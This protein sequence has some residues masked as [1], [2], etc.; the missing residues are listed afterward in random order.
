MINITKSFA[1]SFPF[2]LLLLITYVAIVSSKSE[3][4]PPQ[5][6]QQSK[7]AVSEV[8]Q[9]N[10][11]KSPTTSQVG[12]SEEIED[13]LEKDDEDEDNDSGGGNS[14]EED[15]E[16][17]AE[18][19]GEDEGSVAEE[20]EYAGELRAAA[21]K[22]NSDESIANLASPTESRKQV[23]ELR[24]HRR[25][26]KSSTDEEKAS[27][28]KRESSVKKELSSQKEIFIAE[29]ET[30]LQLDRPVR[31]EALLDD[32]AQ[33]PN[34]LSNELQETENEDR[35]KKMYKE[36][37]P[38]V[39]MYSVP[40]AK[41]ALKKLNKR[42]DSLLTDLKAY[43]LDER[44]KRQ[45]LWDEQGSATESLLKL[46]SKLAENPQRWE[47]VH[48]LLT[49]IRADM[50]YS[51][52]AIQEQK[53][54]SQMVKPLT[55]RE[56]TLT[57]KPTRKSK[58]KKKKKKKKP[59]HLTTTNVE[60]L[61]AT[62]E[63]PWLTTLS[64]A[65]AKWRLVAERLLGPSWSQESSGGDEVDKIHSST[66]SKSH[67][68]HRLLDDKQLENLKAL[69]SERQ[70]L[71][72]KAAREYSKPRTVHY[73]K[74]RTHQQA[75]S[76]KDST[77]EYDAN[78]RAHHYGKLI[79]SSLSHENYPL[80][81]TYS[82]EQPDLTSNHEY[83]AA[84]RD[85]ATDRSNSAN[86]WPGSRTGWN[87]GQVAK[88]WLSWD[89]ER[90]YYAKLEQQEQ[91]EALKTWHQTQQRQ[92][93]QNL[94]RHRESLPPWLEEKELHRLMSKT[95]Q[96]RPQ[97]IY[98]EQDEDIWG[99]NL[100]KNSELKN[101]D[102]SKSDDYSKE[103][104]KLTMKTWNSLTS[105]PATWPFKLPGAKP[106]PKDENGKSYNPNAELLR[107]LGL[108][109]NGRPRPD[110]DAL[111]DLKQQNIQN[112]KSPQLSSKLNSWME[113]DEQQ[114]TWF[115]NIKLHASYEDS[116]SRWNNENLSS[117]SN[118]EHVWGREKI[119]DEWNPAKTASNT[120]P[121]KWKQF[122]YHKVTAQPTSDKPSK[123]A[124]IA[125]SAV[126][127][128]KYGNQWRKNNIEEIEQTN[129]NGPGSEDPDLPINQMRMNIWKKNTGLNGTAITAN[130]VKV[131]VLQNQ[132]ESLRGRQEEP[133]LL[134]LNVSIKNSTIHKEIESSTAVPN[135]QKVTRNSNAE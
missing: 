111:R 34:E 71:M 54:L 66:S 78:Q 128:P 33:L 77:T 91:E 57:P 67:T 68:M 43:L 21:G 8:P 84:E 56:P 2:T 32:V 103:S 115:N 38:V 31:N 121:T 5:Q 26:K 52:Q 46:L 70:V 29:N 48:Q 127:A 94:N 80:A 89:A 74:I 55:P 86:W 88:P 82:E 16:D 65:A 3:Q 132:L 98:R 11:T 20:D 90:E 93:L 1:R 120:W 13:S 79:S 131:D 95:D 14:T 102:R 23:R 105:D 47:R 30:R 129:E 112:N 40:R 51:R 101:D 42:Q 62:T 60:S 39:P 130:T 19:D 119:P 69:N 106:W 116:S 85:F 37:V 50:D 35:E 114:T 12:S 125:V 36:S 53:R 107:K 10:T 28:D 63:I 104:P 99:N 113:P 134:E 124:F 117:S 25:R 81:A 24:E 22:V 76:S 123:N 122:A 49:D 6:Q 133:V 126:S 45:Q 96:M 100:N 27:K 9:S 59:Q 135:M 110:K 118:N 7:A 15:D 72:L 87:W 92:R 4:S 44:L 64:P 109:K 61:I 73:G 83:L 58:K 17:S 41:D 97:G 75:S 108:Y 18:E